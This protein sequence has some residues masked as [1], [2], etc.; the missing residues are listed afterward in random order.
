ML[1]GPS[2]GGIF[3]TLDV[4]TALYES[5][6]PPYVVRKGDDIPVALSRT[7]TIPDMERDVKL[8]ETEAAL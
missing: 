8:E 7:Y 6:I 2:F 5:G 4:V 1:D 3:Q